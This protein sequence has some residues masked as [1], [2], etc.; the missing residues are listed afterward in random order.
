MGGEGTLIL[1]IG[2]FIRAEGRQPVGQKETLQTVILAIVIHIVL[3]PALCIP[4][5]RCRTLHI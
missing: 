2:R 1:G 5:L 4:P 3:L